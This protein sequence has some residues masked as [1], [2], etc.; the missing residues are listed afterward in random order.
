MGTSVHIADSNPTG[1]YEYHLHYET[2]RGGETVIPIGLPCPLWAAFQIC[3]GLP[4][5]L[6]EWEWLEPALDLVLNES[7]LRG[8]LTIANLRL[9]FGPL[10]L[11][12]QGVVAQGHERRKIELSNIGWDDEENFNPWVATVLLDTG[13]SVVV[14]FNAR[15]PKKRLWEWDQDITESIS[16]LNIGLCV[17]NRDRIVQVMARQSSVKEH[18]ELVNKED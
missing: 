11:F 15:S 7:K 5:A 13:K 1:V 12:A 4:G 8:E 9:N 16:H 14:P 18:A 10:F 2:T 6:P 3:G 17:F